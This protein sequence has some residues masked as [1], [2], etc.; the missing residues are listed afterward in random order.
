[1]LQLEKSVEES[2]IFLF[3]QLAFYVIVICSIIFM[4]M[5]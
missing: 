1:L 3:T 5:I 2:A 4:G